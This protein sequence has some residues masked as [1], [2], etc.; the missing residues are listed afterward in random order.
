[1]KIFPHRATA[2]D[3]AYAIHTEVG[4][5]CTGAKIDG[6]IVPLRY[7][8]QNGDRVSI[9]TSPTQNPKRAWLNIV[10][11]GRAISKIRH[12]IREEE[13]QT[14]ILF[15]KELLEKELQSHNLSLNK[16]LKNGKLRE[17][18]KHFGHKQP[19]QLYLAIASGTTTLN[20]LMKLL[21]PETQKPQ[22]T[23]L[24]NFISRMRSKP[25]SPVL[26]HGEQNVLTSFAKCCSPLPGEKIAGF[27]TRGKGVTIHKVECK[28][29]LHSDP[30][31]RISVQWHSEVQGQHF[32]AMEIICSNK[33]GLLADL[34]AACKTM[35]I[36]VNRMEGKSLDDN[37]AE[38]YLEVVIKDVSELKALIRTIR[39]ISG[40]LQA[41][42]ISAR[43]S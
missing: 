43:A 23:T 27:I 33:T 25:S 32:S 36:N 22:R 42:R 38:F 13:R 16:L 40:V 11:T 5:R 26:I 1:M 10:K 20:K 31:R 9:L 34:G 19:E 24:G 29:L 15:G 8:L 41:R 30:S 12:Y 37:K 17:A 21:A 28:Q 7:E 39:K 18:Y 3:F 6:R 35:N 14:G 2:L 4:N